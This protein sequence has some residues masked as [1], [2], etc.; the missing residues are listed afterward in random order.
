MTEDLKISG[1]DRRRAC[2]RPWQQARAQ[3]CLLGQICGDALG[4][5]VEFYGDAGEIS[6]HF[7]NGVRDMFDGGAFDTLAGQPSDVSEMAIVLARALIRR[8]G[9][10]QE[11]LRAAYADWFN[12][13]PC[14][15]TQTA[16][17][18]N[19]GR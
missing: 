1:A 9:F 11:D 6:R 17:A 13:G 3:G 19:T 14:A 12:S 15:A 4:S 10:D 18:R 8:G 2:D 5:G 7:P 16:P